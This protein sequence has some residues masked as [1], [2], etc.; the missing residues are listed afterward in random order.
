MSDK[1][2]HAQSTKETYRF[3]IEDS[4]NVS[5]ESRYGSMYSV[6][7]IIVKSDTLLGEL[8]DENS[9]FGD[10]VVY[11][12]QILFKGVKIFEFIRP[13]IRKIKETIKDHN[14]I[15]PSFIKG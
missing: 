15:S 9:Q 13:N 2:F 11:L 1:T 3:D 6:D 7:F 10:K 8:R 14:L 5:M 12:N 4:Y